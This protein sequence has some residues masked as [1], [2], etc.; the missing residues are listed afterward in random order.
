MDTRSHRPTRHEGLCIGTVGEPFP[1]VRRIAVLRGGGLGDLLFALPAIE[2]LRA[3]YPGAGLVLL[4]SSLHARLLDGRP[5]PVDEVLVLPGEGG[6]ASPEA[7]RSFL[8]EARRIP[9][10]LGVQLH[11]GGAWSNPFVNGLRARFTVGCRAEGAAPLQRTIP[12]RYYQNETMRALEVAC[13]AGAPPV[14]LEP[15]VQV[16]E[17]D[18]DNA[19]RVLG[20]PDRPLVAL[21]PGA[22]DPRR[23]WPVE[24]FAA[25][26]AHCVDEG[27]DVIL[28]GTAHE[29]NLLDAVAVQARAR[30]PVLRSGGI[31]QLA[32]A[33]M[34]TLCG[35]LA[36]SSVLVGNDSG[37]RH[38]ARAVGTPTV[39]VFWIGNVINAGPVARGRDRVLMSWR[40]E[41]PVCGETFTDE[42]RPRCPHDETIVDTVTVAQVRAELDDL[43]AASSYNGY[44]RRDDALP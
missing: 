35:V 13:L 43:L 29:L 40:I 15:R 17:A 7:E 37:P 30:G 18:L 27:F 24:S 9:V 16:T 39:G 1:D 22:T 12:F 32:G 23:R 11:G 42:T 10:D 33:D 28:V 20:S 44:A 36:R 5:S 3:A 4:G 25:I 26:A 6:A 34:S 41:C 8:R 2:A 38:L 21:H 14:L 31:R 19:D